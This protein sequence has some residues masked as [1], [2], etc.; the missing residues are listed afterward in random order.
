[1]F[2]KIP[3]RLIRHLPYAWA[4]RASHLHQSCALCHHTLDR[5][6]RLLCESCL[7]NMP[8]R[9][10]A[11]PLTIETAQ[12]SR[13]M[14]LY[15]ASYYQY[16]VNRLM[17]QLKDR[18]DGNALLAL[19]RL[20]QTLP[21]PKQCHANN[22]IIIPSPTTKT[23]LK[24]RG[25]DPV[26]ML[27]RHL[28]EH[29]QLPIF[30]GLARFDDDQHQRGLDRQA[31]LQNI[32]QKFYLKQPLSYKQVILFDDVATTGATMQAMAAAILAKN[33]DTRILAVCVAH[34]SQS[35]V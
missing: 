27:V 6:D 18:Q 21:K 16:P 13:T 7:H 19:V 20:L 8:P 29:W 9:P 32:Q 2:A 33:P 25:F 10:P 4:M 30:T 26:L 31:R 34:G 23:R 3:T 35:V 5:H 11:V 17:L 15:A 22:T 24:H 12:S 1:M 28:A 14:R